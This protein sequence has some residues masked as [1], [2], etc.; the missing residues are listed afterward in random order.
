[1]M[2]EREGGTGCHE[3]KEQLTA[4]HRPPLKVKGRLTA[5]ATRG[6]PVR[7]VLLVGP[8][9]GPSPSGVMQRRKGLNKS[10]N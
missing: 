4:T 5:K 2:V 3:E 7:L 10:A 1:M 6:W 9:F 8:V